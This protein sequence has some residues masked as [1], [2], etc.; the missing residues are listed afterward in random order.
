MG[1]E[2]GMERIIN[3]HG[4][5]IKQLIGIPNCAPN[6]F[7]EMELG[8]ES[9]RGKCTHSCHTVYLMNLLSS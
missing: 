6:R 4:R 7:A 8:R 2:R 9:R 1:L 5:F 3:V